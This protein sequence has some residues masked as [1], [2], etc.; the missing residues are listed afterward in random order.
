MIVLAVNAQMVQLYSDPEVPLL[1]FHFAAS[2]FSFTP[3]SHAAIVL[4]ISA[5]LQLI[6]WIFLQFTA[7]R[8]KS[9]MTNT[10]AS[11]IQQAPSHDSTHPPS[12]SFILPVPHPPARDSSQPVY[13][14][15]DVVL[16]SPEYAVGLQKKER[17]ERERLDFLAV[18]EMLKKEE[19]E[20]QRQDLL[21]A[22]VLFKLEP[23]IYLAL[24]ENFD[25]MITG[26]GRAFGPRRSRTTSH[27]K[28]TAG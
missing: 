12:P 19:E 15:Q 21:A 13:S 10:G 2:L 1:Q 5:G 24:S 23:L 25:A 28:T 18:K 3:L 4:F 6:L 22:K 14:L 26:F 8:T 9:R 27:S 17:N 20:R 7:S 16:T 11:V